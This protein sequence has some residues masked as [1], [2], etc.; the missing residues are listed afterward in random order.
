MGSLQTPH[1]LQSDL[2]PPRKGQKIPSATSTT[3]LLPVRHQEAQCTACS[4]EI[5]PQVLAPGRGEGMRLLQAPGCPPAPPRHC[6]GGRSGRVGLVPSCGTVPSDKALLGHLPA[7]Q[8]LHPCPRG[9]APMHVLSCD[10][11]QAVGVGSAGWRLRKQQ[12]GAAGTASCG[13][14]QAPRAGDVPSCAVRDVR[15]ARPPAFSKGGRSPELLCLP[16]PV[17]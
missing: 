6:G 16:G 10:T 17:P 2:F 3:L 11:E 13:T 1:T 7:A 5:Q 12:Q 14:A 9:A 15:W 8:L 4:E